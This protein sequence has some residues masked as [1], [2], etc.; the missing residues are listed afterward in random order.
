MRRSAI[1]PLWLKP[2][3]SVLRERACRS[4]EDGDVEAFFGCADSDYSMQLFYKNGR[5]FRDMG[6]FEKALLNAWSNQ[7]V[8]SGW[9]EFMRLMLK[10]CNR[11]ALLLWSESIPKGDDSLTVYRGVVRCSDE[12]PTPRG[13]S[14]TLDPA[15]A[16]GFAHRVGMQGTVYRTTVARSEVY[17]YLS[18]KEGR[19]GEKEVLLVL[20]DDHPIESGQVD[21]DGNFIPE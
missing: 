8:T 6:I 5:R 20:A 19:A 16:A 12:K 7:K 4:L 18:D 3:H 1:R 21:L 2:V 14:W 13:V 17:A 11:E 10:M 9:G 15:V